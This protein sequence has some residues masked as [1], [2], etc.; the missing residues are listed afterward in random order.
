MPRAKSLR[1]SRLLAGSTGP[2]EL[3]SP[4]QFCV[5]IR[6]GSAFSSRGSIRQ[7]AASGE[8]GRSLLQ[9]GPHQFECASI[10]ALPRNNL[11]KWRQ[12]ECGF[13]QFCDFSCEIV[14]DYGGDRTPDAR[15]ERRS[16]VQSELGSREREPVMSMIPPSRERPPERL[17]A[18]RK[19]NRAGL[20]AASQNKF[21]SSVDRP[22]QTTRENQSKTTLAPE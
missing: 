4:L 8:A 10:P 19:A 20:A 16:V 13:F 7:T 15:A 1:F 9:P 18:D 22:R 14:Q 5:R 17:R 6:N 2:N 3:Q 12:L 21:A 11:R